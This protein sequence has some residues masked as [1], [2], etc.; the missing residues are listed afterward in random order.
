MRQQGRS[1]YFQ[2]PLPYVAF[3]VAW[4][5]AAT[6]TALRSELGLC[7]RS[8]HRNKARDSDKANQYKHQQHT[9]T[10]THNDTPTPTLQRSADKGQLDARI[11]HTGTKED[12]RKVVGDLIRHGLWDNDESTMCHKGGV[13]ERN[14]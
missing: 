4:Q 11:E 2:H 8:T 1:I 3:I 7:R 9:S 13:C 5:R 6:W 10:H 12:D 14:W